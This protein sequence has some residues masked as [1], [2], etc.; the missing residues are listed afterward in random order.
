MDGCRDPEAAAKWLLY[1]TSEEA[2]RK[3]L[4]ETGELPSLK[5]VAE[6]PKYKNDP[7]LGAVV[8]SLNYA[9]PTFS[10][11]WANPASMLRDGYNDIIKKGVPIE[12]A[13]ARV[14]KEINKYLEETFGQFK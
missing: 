5:V 1:I 8:D 6:D 7:L 14:V 9:E 10:K 4:E 3:W 11:G 13:A 2:Q 12:E